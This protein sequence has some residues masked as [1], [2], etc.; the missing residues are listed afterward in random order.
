MLRPGRA[1]LALARAQ[2]AACLV[3]AAK[4]DILAFK[5]GLDLGGVGGCGMPPPS[6]PLS[7]RQSFRRPSESLGHPL[8]PL[9]PFRRVIVKGRLGGSELSL[10]AP[11]LLGL[12]C[13]G[14]SLT[15]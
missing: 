13:E 7:G 12:V 9:V 2:S 14:I 11:G 15:T 1:L 10:P 8:I 6:Q 4:L 3:V 5:V